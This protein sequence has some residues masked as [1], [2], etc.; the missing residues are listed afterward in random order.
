LACPIYTR[1]SWIQRFLFDESLKGSKSLK[2]F[3]ISLTFRLTNCDIYQNPFTQEK[4][5]KFWQCR[6]KA[7]CS[8][9]TAIIKFPAKAR[10]SQSF[11]V[12]TSVCSLVLQKFYFL[13]VKEFHSWFFISDFL[14]VLSEWILKSLVWYYGGQKC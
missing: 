7:F 5:L 14:A 4:I 6:T 1:T 9:S 2:I 11:N 8:N 13:K 10:W 3:K 12:V